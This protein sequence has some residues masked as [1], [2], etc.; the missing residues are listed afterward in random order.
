MIIVKMLGSWAK[1]EIIKH[2][3]GLDDDSNRLRFGVRKSEE[4]IKQY[5][6]GI[7]FTS[8][9]LYGA[10]DGNVNMVGFIHIANMTKKNVVEIGIS[11]DSR[12][13]K[14]RIGSKLFRKAV[15]YCKLYNIRTLYSFCL[16]ENSAM[17]RMA[18]R[19]NMVID[20]FA[21]EA[22]AHM[23]IDELARPDEYFNEFLDEIISTA[24]LMALTYLNNFKNRG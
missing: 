5:V 11:V 1:E 23:S 19:E 9:R 21:G 14:L 6:E 22:E 13:R 8:D 4:S 15:N 12:Y 7:N 20:R 2:L 18:K 24:E 10:F 3:I 16:T 17:M